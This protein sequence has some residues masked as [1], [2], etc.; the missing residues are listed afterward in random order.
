MNAS[1]DVFAMTSGAAQVDAE[2][3][4]PARTGLDR[5]PSPLALDERAGDGQT[6]PD[7]GGVGRAGRLA[8][9]EALEEPRQLLGRHAGSG[10]GDSYDGLASGHR[11]GG[12]HQTAG[13][14]EL[15]GVVEDIGE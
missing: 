3:G 8:A 7:T 13:R 12:P 2:R 1:S 11:H 4:S 5:D 14:R 9:V 15:H 10:V 6:E